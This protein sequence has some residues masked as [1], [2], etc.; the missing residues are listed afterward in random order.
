MSDKL[1]L[2]EFCEER[3]IPDS[4]RIAFG[5]YVSAEMGKRFMMSKEGETVKLMMSR[6]TLE[7]LKEYWDRFVIDLKDYLS[8]S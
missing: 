7:H 3:L 8:A 1:P 4:I 6:I 5:A 2:H